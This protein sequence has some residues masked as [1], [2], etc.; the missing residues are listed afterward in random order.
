[1]EAEEPSLLK[2]LLLAPANT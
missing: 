2:K 1:Q